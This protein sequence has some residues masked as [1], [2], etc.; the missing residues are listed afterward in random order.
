VDVGRGRSAPKAAQAWASD[1]PREALR[2]FLAGSGYYL[3]SR[4]GLQA[5]FPGVGISLFWPANAFLLA[6]LLLT[7]MRRWWPC[8]LVVLPAHLLVVSAFQPGVPAA[9]MIC[10]YAGNLVQ[11]VVAALA[12]S[13]FI[14]RPPPLDRLGSMASYITLAAL[15]APALASALVAWL[16]VL[17]GWTDDYWFT[18]RQRFLGNVVPSLTIP[19]LIILAARRRSVELREVPWRRYAEVAAVLSALLVVH[20]AVFGKEPAG[21]LSST[22]LV[23]AP[24]PLLLWAAVRFGVGG[25]CLSLLTFAFLSL[26]AT[27][28]GRGPFTVQSPEANAISLQIFLIGTSIPLMLLAALVEERRRSEGALRE[29]QQRY[30][31]AAAAG[32][33]GVWEWNLETNG[34]YVDGALRALFGL[35]ANEVGDH[36][37]DWLRLVHPDDLARLQSL[38][39]ANLAGEAESFDAE[40]RAFHKDGSSRWFLSRGAIERDAGPRRLIGTSTDITQRKLAEE[41]ARVKVEEARA[42]ASQIAHLNRIVTVGELS[43]AIAHEISQPLTGVMYNAEAAI[44]LLE[45]AEPDWQEV[46][47]ALDDIVEDDRRASDVIGRVR[48]LLRRETSLH[49]LLDMRHTVEQVLPLVHRDVVERG[50]SLDIRLGSAA[51]PVMGERTQLQQVLL[52]L[53]LNAFDALAVA[54]VAGRQVVLAAEVA[55]DRVVVSI[56]DNGPGVPDDELDLLFQPFF[57]TKPTGIGLGLSI[58]RTIV[59]SHDGSL[60]ARRNGDGGG[61]TFSLT[62]PLSA[63]SS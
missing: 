29:S 61:M 24:L 45:R 62:L 20:A 7:P 8:L 38:V 3:A 22:A 59:A 49:S 28:A 10:Q 14:G 39:R 35:E 46:R 32:G 56:V 21:P 40:Y 16:F 63:P 44:R 19:P 33:V 23:Y 25:V 53:L 2:V 36:P 12:V 17:T 11:A 47:A 18:L 6:V 60:E 54:P 4:L 58:C 41:Q 9:T 27:F 57:T 42:L 31:L 52:N 5:R 37:N 51:L 55:G 15:L 50:I 34:L 48:G 13:R 30:G 26:S 1:L 43:A